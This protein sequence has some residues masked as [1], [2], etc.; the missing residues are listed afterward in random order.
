MKEPLPGR[1]LRFRRGTLR[2]YH[3]NLFMPTRDGKEMAIHVGPAGEALFNLIEEEQRYWSNA[4]Q[5]A[6]R[7]Y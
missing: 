4:R 6:L 5:D 7:G 3:G 2:L 1:K